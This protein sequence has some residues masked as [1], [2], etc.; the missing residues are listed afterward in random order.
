M[1]FLHRR[2]IKR[3]KA[4]DAADRHASLDF[5]LGEVHRKKKA[6][7]KGAGVE[8][9]EFDS[10]K[11]SRQLSMDMSSPYLLPPELQSSRESLRSMSRSGH[12][13][14]DPYRPVEQYLAETGSM[15]S[16]RPR[17]DGSSIYTGSSGPSRLQDT[18]TAELL[19]NAQ[20]M[21]RTSPPNG[22]VLP[23]RQNSLARDPTSPIDPLRN[24]APG[25]PG[26][27]YNPVEAPAGIV[28][29][30]QMPAP[31]AA[32]VARK[33]L[34]TGVPGMIPVDGARGNSPGRGGSPAPPPPPSKMPEYISELPNEP[35]IIPEMAA[36]PATIPRK[37]PP[38]SIILPTDQMPPRKQS[39]P[40]AQQAVVE[41]FDATSDYGD[42]FQVTPPSPGR[43]EQ[44]RGQRYSMDVPPEEFVQAGLGAPGFDAKRLSMG[45]RPLPPDSLTAD[46]EDPETRANRIRSFYKEYFDDSKPA[47]QGQ[48]YEDYDQNYLE[49]SQNYLGD[50]AYYDPDS[51]QFVMPGA[52]PITRRAM[53]PP[54]QAQRFMGQGN[55]PPRPF[56]GQGPPRPRNGSM[57]G[58]SSNGPRFMGGNGGPRPY[59]SASN[60]GPGPRAYSSASGRGPSPRGR[61]L[62]P[63]QALTS[64]PTPSKLRDDSF[65]LMGATDFAPPVSYRDRQHGRSESPLGDRRPYSPLVPA[66]RPLATAYDEL[67]PIPSP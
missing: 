31:V 32:P 19:S 57:G 40:V 42:G 23:P 48:Y 14:E 46:V 67:A 61:P 38:Q 43:E 3:Q 63:P 4:E 7:E 24:G 56:M 62:P 35:M 58:M 54:P 27:V 30:L 51:N 17:H 28:P 25:T 52:A 47:P 29:V 36:P 11:H 15:R 65:A 21:S 33:G 13:P 5:G 53:T 55:G 22:F 20:R 50:A 1:I 49:D 45:F 39:L 41:D 26:G 34:S 66:H 59:S 37:S 10:E 16:F 44:I 8:T 2:H 18:S 60:R 6:G 12:N 9:S 64:L